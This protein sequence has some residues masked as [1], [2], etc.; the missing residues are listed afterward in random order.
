MSVLTVDDSS[1]VTITATGAL[2]H[3]C[4]YRNEIDR[5]HVTITWRVDGKSYELHSL[6][7]YL[8]GFA[9]VEVSHEQ[10]TDHIS[11]D[12]SVIAGIELLSVETTWTTAGMEVRCSTSPIP[13]VVTP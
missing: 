5:G 9:D 11:H 10:I 3:R 2:R 6:A 12:L 7:E 1:D 13:A 4:P 8:S